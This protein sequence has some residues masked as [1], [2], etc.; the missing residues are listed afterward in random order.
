MAADPVRSRP[1]IP[2]YGIPEAEEGLLSWERTD[3]RLRSASNYW[4]ATANEGGRPHAVP[5]QGAWIDTALYF[6][7]GPDV[8]WARNLRANPRVSI[9]LE[10]GDDVVILEGIVDRVEEPQELMERIADV[11]ESKYGFR[12]PSPFWLLRPRVAFAWTQFDK[13]PT[14]FRFSGAS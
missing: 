2:D 11:Y 13:D 10:S 8:L 1:Y 5:V 12:H 4:L 3:E 6:G 7:G 9:H 14:R